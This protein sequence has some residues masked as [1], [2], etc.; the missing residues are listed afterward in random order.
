MDQCCGNCIWNENGFCDRIGILVEDD[1][2]C[3]K[4]QKELK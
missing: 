3:K 2:C 1:E 4:H